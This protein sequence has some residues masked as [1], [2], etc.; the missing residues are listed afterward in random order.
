MTVCKKNLYQPQELQKQGY[1]NAVKFRN[2]APSNK[3]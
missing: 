2:Y 1:D 3:V